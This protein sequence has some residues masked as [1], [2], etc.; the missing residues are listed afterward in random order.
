MTTVTQ[1]IDQASAMLHSYSGNLEAN[2]YLTVAMNTTDLVVNVAH[3]SYINRGLIEVGDELMHV[4]S[5]GD[6]SATLM[7]FGRGVMNSQVATHPLNGRVTN[8]P[9]FPRAQIY[10]ALKRCIQNV[11]L[12]LFMVKSTTFTYSNVQTTYPMPVDTVRVLDVQWETV[13]PSK[14]WVNLRGWDFDANA[15]TVTGKAIVLRE[16]VQAGRTVAVNYA[17][18]LPVPATTAIDLTASGIPDWMQPVLLYGTCWEMVQFMEPQRL[19]LRSVEQRQQAALDPAGAASN[20]AKQLYGMYQLRLENAR[21]R[22]LTLNPTTKHYVR[23]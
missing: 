17:A 5:V 20:L 10:E 18:E 15:A 16:L 19:N 6:T 8:D 13:G 14:E 12:D 22:L 21:K 9:Q 11:Q 2:T 4:A 1:T 23:Y 3:P 7:P